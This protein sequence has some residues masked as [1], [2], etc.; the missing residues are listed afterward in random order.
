ME[1]H[2]SLG[3]EQAI[4]HPLRV[5]SHKVPCQDLTSNPIIS[6]KLL[7]CCWRSSHIFFWQPTQGQSV[8][9]NGNCRQDTQI[10]GWYSL[11]YILFPA[12][13][14]SSVKM[15]LYWFITIGPCPTAS[16]GISTGATV[17]R[18]YLS[19]VWQRWPRTISHVALRIG[20]EE[21]WCN[22]IWKHDR[23]PNPN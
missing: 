21:V 11:G 6:Q 16:L 20:P 14:S 5:H 9:V 23:V 2:G 12:H 15:A 17:P 1:N 19:I 13:L 3:G 22:C 7:K 8:E 18:Q 10:C 4:T